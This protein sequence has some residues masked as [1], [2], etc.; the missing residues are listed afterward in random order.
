V[1]VI[2]TN[3]N[4]KCDHCCEP[5]CEHDYVISANVNKTLNISPIMKILKFKSIFMKSQLSRV[6]CI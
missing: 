3:L 6:V 2:L 4:K 1:K 5:K